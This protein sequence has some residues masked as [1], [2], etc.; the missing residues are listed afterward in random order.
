LGEIR[1]IYKRNP[2]HD[3]RVAAGGIKTYAESRAACR[4]H[5]DYRIFV[6]YRNR[7]NREAYTI[8]GDYTFFLGYK[9]RGNIVEHI[10]ENTLFLDRNIEYHYNHPSL[11]F[12]DHPN[13]YRT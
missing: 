13:L 6:D 4:L 10:G 7:D 2:G 12:P 3:D 5:A 8:H 1:R 11:V 9:I